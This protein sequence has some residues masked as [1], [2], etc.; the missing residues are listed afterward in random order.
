MT[1]V[2]SLTEKHS[3]HLILIYVKL[4]I[5][6][7][8]TGMTGRGMQH[9]GVGGGGCVCVGGVVWNIKYAKLKFKQNHFKVDSI[10]KLQF[11][12]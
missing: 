11:L 12:P 10:N 6:K 4:F 2:Q 1:A 7:S 3:Q 5:I 8:W 9:W